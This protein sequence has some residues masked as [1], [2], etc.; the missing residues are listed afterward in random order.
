MSRSIMGYRIEVHTPEARTGFYIDLAWEE[1]ECPQD[2][3]A[4]HF[5]RHGGFNAWA[6]AQDSGKFYFTALGAKKFLKKT[7]EELGENEMPYTVINR[8][9]PMEDIVI[10]HPDQVCAVGG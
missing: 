3:H 1:L 5:V 10:M 6:T 9:I 4:S 7:I 8:R 2:M